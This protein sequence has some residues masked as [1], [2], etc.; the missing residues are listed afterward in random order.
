MDV[1]WIISLYGLN[2]LALAGTISIIFHF[3]YKLI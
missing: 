1:G 3:I 2:I